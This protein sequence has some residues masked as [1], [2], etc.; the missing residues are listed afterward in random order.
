M[1]E[2]RTPKWD[3]LRTDGAPSGGRTHTGRILS[4]LSLPL[5]YEGAGQILGY[6][7]VIPIFA[8]RYSGINK[9]LIGDKQAIKTG[10][11]AIPPKKCGDSSYREFNR[12]LTTAVRLKIT[13]WVHL[14]P[15]RVKGVSSP[16]R[17]QKRIT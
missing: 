17:S 5:D 13:F 2:K 15:Q 6:L 12:I 11:V 4:P 14:R 9:S 7:G 3:D 1:L 8:L 16:G 10:G